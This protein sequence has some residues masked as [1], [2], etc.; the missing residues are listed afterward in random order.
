MDTYLNGQ[1]KQGENE[2]VKS[3]P[4]RELAAAPETASEGR[5]G[6]GSAE[7][8]SGCSSQ[9]AAVNAWSQAPN[10]HKTGNRH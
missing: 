3:V 4:G 10:R 2:Y 1:E 8:V 5:V 9:Q 7:Q 6:A